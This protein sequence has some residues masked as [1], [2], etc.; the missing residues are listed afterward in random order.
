MLAK[1]RYATGRDRGLASKE[2]LSLLE[3]FVTS[4]LRD[5]RP[6]ASSA[7][8]SEACGGVRR[9]HRSGQ[10]PSPAAEPLPVSEAGLGQEE[11]PMPS[12]A[13]RFGMQLNG[14][15]VMQMTLN[16][17][18]TLAY[19]IQRH[20]LVGGPGPISTDDRHQRPERGRRSDAAAGAWRS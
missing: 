4:F 16:N 3:V 9:G 5:A 1:V 11:R 12:G 19:G 2:V 15:F 17:L 20:Q 14:R 8:S 7:W 10:G 6:S 18:M 13:L